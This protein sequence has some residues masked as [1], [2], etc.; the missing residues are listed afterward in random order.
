MGLLRFI[1]IA[2]IVYFIYRLVKKAQLKK[3]STNANPA[4]AMVKCQQ[5]RVLFPA[6]DAIT[7][8][9]QHFCCT[10]HLNQWLNEHE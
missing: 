6:S 4:I 7:K 2:A 1:F 3:V 10:E 8:K 9:G 5:C